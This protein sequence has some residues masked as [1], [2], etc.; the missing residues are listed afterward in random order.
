VQQLV[1]Q[2]PDATLSELCERLAKH[3]GIQVSVPT[4]HRAVQRLE[5]STKK[6]HFMPVSKTAHELNKCALSIGIGC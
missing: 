4:M 2:Q 6:K 1:D 5:L 3:N